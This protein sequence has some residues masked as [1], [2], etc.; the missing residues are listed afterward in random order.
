MR[1]LYIAPG[2]SMSLMQEVTALEVSPLL[3]ELIL[4]IHTLDMLVEGMDKHDRLAGLLVDMIA[5]SP[6]GHLC[7]AMPGE[8]RAVAAARWI[9]DN[10]GLRSDLKTLAQ[11]HGCSLRTLQRLFVK[12]TG[13][14]LQ[15]WRQK[16]RLIYAVTQLNDGLSVTE[17]AFGCGYDSVS[18][19]IAAFK[20]HFGVTPGGYVS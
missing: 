13:L 19:F 17:T 10:P 18:A 15:A 8:S 9:Q 20:K 4:H 14:T 1:T 7:L 11:S 5:D 16:S 6:V 2:R 3:R 12:E